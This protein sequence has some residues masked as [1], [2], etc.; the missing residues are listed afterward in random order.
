MSAEIRKHYVCV[1]YPLGYQLENDNSWRYM[2]EL[3]NDKRLSAIL[4]TIDEF[5]LW[6][7]IRMQEEHL[8]LC[9]NDKKLLESLKEKRILLEANTLSELLKK[10]LL[11]NPIRQGTGLIKEY[12]NIITDNSVCILLGNAL[13]Y[14]T[15]LECNIWRKSSG[16]SFV[17]NILDSCVDT[18]KKSLEA[19]EEDFVSAILKLIKYDVLRLR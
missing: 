19:F 17:S 12:D 13:V 9:E 6:S 5:K 8:D 4:I 3:A 10:I 14:P 2:F 7:R 1:G 16:T 18:T 11:L 15:N